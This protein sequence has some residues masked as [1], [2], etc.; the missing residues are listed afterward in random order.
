MKKKLVWLLSVL[1]VVS[2]LTGCW[3]DRPVEERGMVLMLGVAPAPHH[4][5]TLYFEIPTAAG[6][7][8]LTGGGSSGSSSGP[9]FM[10]YRGQGSDFTDAYTNAQGQTNEDLYLGQVQVIA[11]S[12][13]LT[14]EQ[15]ALTD[16]TFARLG[17]MDKS[18]DA[19]AVSG[20]MGKFMDFSPAGT[21]LPG[22][23]LASLFACHHCQTAHLARTVWS[24]EK[25]LWSPTSSV[26]VPE[27]SVTG[28]TFEVDRMVVYHGYKPVM[29]LTPRQTWDLGFLLGI[30]AKAPLSVPLADGTIGLRAVH[31]SPRFKT[32]SLPDGQLALHVTLRLTATLDSVPANMLTTTSLLHEIQTK[33]DTI[34]SHRLL[35]ILVTVQ[36]T[37]ANPL[38]FGRRYA[39]FHQDF[40]GW[41]TQYRNAALSVTVHTLIHQLGDLQ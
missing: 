40:T 13:R 19:V 32:R 4:G 1:C 11:L 26:W 6:L 33:A 37:G 41:P 7:T 39:W 27:I 16:A 18:A 31:A 35:A 34:L 24:R 28:S 30:T 3:D 5:L 2:L 22:L 17:P 38:G 15:F 12:T 25:R 9:K 20:S 23:Y 21:S 8:G 10:V 36:K 29:V 14:P